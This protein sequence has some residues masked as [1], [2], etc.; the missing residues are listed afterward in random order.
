VRRP[1]ARGGG[2]LVARDFDGDDAPDLFLGGR[3]GPA[4]LLRNQRYR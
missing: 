1:F 4:L 3:L 2:A